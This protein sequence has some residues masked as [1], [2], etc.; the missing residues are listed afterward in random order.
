[1]QIDSFL[2]ASYLHINN[3]HLSSNNTTQTSSSQ[4][5]EKNSEELTASQKALVA[6]LQATDTAVRAH[7]SAHIA[8]GGGVIRSSAVFTYVQAPDKRL[9][10]VGGEVGIDTS[11][12]STPEKRLQKCKPCV[13]QHSH[14]LIQVLLTIKWLQLLPCFK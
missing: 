10:A 6:E 11:E 7:E 3:T 5:K 4:K 12:G 2:N 8:A 1:M 13:P 9:Y 14:P